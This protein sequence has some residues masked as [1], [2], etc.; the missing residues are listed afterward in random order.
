MSHP[1]AFSSNQS[2]HITFSLRMNGKES[3]L[4]VEA[5]LRTWSCLSVFFFFSRWQ[6]FLFTTIVSL[7]GANYSHMLWSLSFSSAFYGPEPLTPNPLVII[8]FFYWWTCLCC[9]DASCIR[10]KAL[11]VI[12][13]CWSLCIVACFPAL[14]MI[15]L[16]GSGFP[17]TH[18]LPRLLSHPPLISSWGCVM[19]V[20]S[21]TLWWTRLV[22]VSLC[23]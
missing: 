4:V 3:L 9:E 8:F 16:W 17:L 21:R 11:L 12:C 15:G 22:L 5:V 23:D 10:W 20:P 2:R 7:E 19:Y 13:A 18:L 14:T 1:S 6:Q